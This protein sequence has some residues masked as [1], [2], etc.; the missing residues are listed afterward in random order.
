MTPHIASLRAFLT[1]PFLYIL[2]GCSLWCLDLTFDL[3]Q[4]F[5]LSKLSHW[6]APSPAISLLPGLALATPPH[7]HHSI[8]LRPS[9]G[10]PHH[11][12]E[13]CSGQSKSSVALHSGH[14]TIASIGPW[15]KA[16]P[17]PW[18]SLISPSHRGCSTSTPETLVLSFSLPQARALT[19]GTLSLLSIV[20]SSFGY[21]TT[22]P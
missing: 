4:S 20:E 19:A 12:V 10:E 21:S 6:K 8:V 1:P 2:G 9:Y 16:L 3:S 11:L 22:L 5:L 15:Y 14:P 17:F 18:Y 7:I 13:P